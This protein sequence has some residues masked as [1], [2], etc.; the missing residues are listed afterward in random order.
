M[1]QVCEP[2]FSS[3]FQG[4]YC[5]ML[6]GYLSSAARTDARSEPSTL[7]RSSGDAT[8]L[9]GWTNCAD[10]EDTVFV[11]PGSHFGGRCRRLSVE[12]TDS[13]MAVTVPS[14]G[15]IFY[16][17]RLTIGDSRGLKRRAGT[18]FHISDSPDSIFES[19]YPILTTGFAVPSSAGRKTLGG[20]PTVAAVFSEPHRWF[21]GG[22]GMRD[23]VLAPVVL[24]T[25][26][27]QLRYMLPA[28]S[29]TVATIAAN[30]VQYAQF[31]A[32]AY[33]QL[34]EIYKPMLFG[35]EEWP[36][37]PPPINDFYF[38]PE[39]IAACYKNHVPPYSAKERQTHLPKFIKPG[40][41]PSIFL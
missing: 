40:V 28:P 18:A 7:V 23:S 15:H 24:V 34:Q 13:L 22:K 30:K 5:E 27:F 39:L 17:S 41:R 26:L 4:K 9:S 21:K 32:L 25:P 38:Y 12:D 11:L 2:I 31:P 36:D 14:G 19:V 6:P 3:S 16:D 1:W 33:Q 29:G 37:Y 8:M 10:A 20:T 35:F